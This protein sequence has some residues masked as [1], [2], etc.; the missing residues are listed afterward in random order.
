[1]NKFDFQTIS[2]HTIKPSLPTPNHLKSFHLSFFDQFPPP[3]YVP[4]ILFYSN[5]NPSCEEK[6]DLLKKSLSETLTQFYMLAGRIRDNTTVECNDEG[7]E[8]FEGKINGKISDFK[9]LDDILY[10]LVP[11]HVYSIPAPS[12]AKEVPLVIQVNMFDCGGIAIAVCMSHKIADAASITT[13]INSWASASRGEFSAGPT[14]DSN[15]LF[16]ARQITFHVP[17]PYEDI[18]S[19]NEKFVTKRFVFDAAKLTALRAKIIGTSST[20]KYPTRVEAVSALI[21]KLA[22]KSSRYPSDVSLVHHVVNLRKRIDPPLSNTSFGNLVS[23]A[24]TMCTS[25]TVAELDELV[26]LLREGINQINCE[27][28]KRMQDDEFLKSTAEKAAVNGSKNEASDET[29]PTVYWMS[30]WCNF[31]LYESDFGWGNPAWVTASLNLLV[32]ENGAIMMDT[33]CGK[34]IEVWLKLEEEQM[35]RFEHDHELVEFVSLGQG[36]EQME[37]GLST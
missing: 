3:V 12:F 35:V 24:T 14:F 15:I 23:M 21:W 19:Q 27:Y 28:I 22:V 2:K 34:G 29:L 17:D 18:S 4:V 7:V 26:G 11:P 25:S 30:S 1:M 5:P 9:T 31:S 6:I 20:M 36:L 32:A 33:K 8:F 16:P 10:Q 37:L 13:F